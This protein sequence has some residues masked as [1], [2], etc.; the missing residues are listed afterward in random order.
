MLAKPKK[1]SRKKVKEDKLVTYYSK[2]LEI[3][4]KYQTQLIIGVGVIAVIILAFVLISNKKEQ[5]NIE[6]TTQLS[7]VLPIYESGN[8]KEAI[9]GRAGTNIVGLE[10]IVAEYG[11]TPQGEI[12]KV[13]LANALYFQGNIEKSLEYYSDYSGDDNIFKAAAIAG[14]ASCYSAMNE[15]EKAAWCIELI[16]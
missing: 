16:V 2:S 15:P 4:E 14:E 10:S 6:A 3:Y 13:F 11:S 8:Y 1:I 12:A 9:E 5:D 7:R